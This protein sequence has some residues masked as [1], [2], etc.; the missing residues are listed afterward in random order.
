MVP[1]ERFRAAAERLGYVVVSSYNTLSDGAIAPNDAAL[2]AMLLAAQE[3]VRVDTARFYLGGFSGTARLA[4]GY[5]AL[6]DGYVA[7][8][9]GVGA[10]LP[11]ADLLWRQGPTGKLRF[12]FFG[13]AGTTD[14]NYEEVRAL[15]RRLD[16]FGIVHHVEYF[17]GGHDWPPEAVCAAALEWMELRAMQRGLRAADPRWL[18]SLY[19]ART[20]EA[21][22]LEAGG[23]VPGAFA[24]YRAMATDFAGLRD[25]AA[26]AGRVRALERSRVVADAAAQADRLAERDRAYQER[27]RTFLAGVRTARQ[28][29]TLAK[30]VDELQIERLRR[31]ATAGDPASARAAQ[32]LLESAFVRTAFYEP[33]DYLERGDRA[34]ALA[35]LDIAQAVKPSDPLVCYSRARVYAALGRPQDALRALDCATANG[36]VSAARL[37]SDSALAPLRGDPG[38]RGLVERSR[39]AGRP[40]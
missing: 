23:D 18:D 28:P 24:R 36:S 8:V 11:S 6:L 38:F 34:R 26:A 5:A 35:V 3:R 21:Q 33:R 30:A 20:S 15:D 29:P 31:E 40:R 32:R 12:A 7:G 9:I 25:T 17:D 4:W 37:E 19:G 13:A 2:D 1:L 16:Q 27:L 22:A 14:F 39:H 10:G